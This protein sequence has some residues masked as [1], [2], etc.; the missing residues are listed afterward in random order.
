[1][2]EATTERSA[3]RSLAANTGETSDADR[4]GAGPSMTGRG[5]KIPGADA[6]RRDPPAAGDG[7]RAPWPPH[8]AGR[9]Q[10]PTLHVE[11]VHIRSLQLYS[12][13]SSAP[14]LL[15]ADH[16]TCCSGSNNRPKLV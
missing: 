4:V 14:E 6:P 8:R 13:N 3:H 9:L 15:L 16:A 12:A 7:V 1:M 2:I 11:L 10:R 5:T